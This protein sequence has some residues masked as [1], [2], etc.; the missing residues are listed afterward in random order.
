MF[1]ILDEILT[2]AL[3]MN[4]TIVIYVIIVMY[5]IIM[6]TMMCC[7]KCNAYDDPDNDDCYSDDVGNDVN[8][9]KRDA[10]ERL[11]NAKC[12][13][14]MKSPTAIREIQD[15]LGDN[16]DEIGINK[17]TGVIFYKCNNI[18]YNVPRCKLSD[19]QMDSDDYNDTES[20]DIDDDDDIVNDIEDD[21]DEHESTD[22]DLLLISTDS[23]LSS[24]SDEEDIINYNANDD[25]DNNDDIN[26][27]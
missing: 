7:C 13:D 16:I 14:H 5:I 22:T 4:T 8:G 1:T 6:I 18:T 3:T 24:S 27:Y 15:D 17:C 25:D 10:T 2:Y 11:M 9:D 21:D 26:D 12:V 20:G 23:D 19:T